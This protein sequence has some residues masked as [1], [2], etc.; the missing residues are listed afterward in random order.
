M[1]VVRENLAEKVTLRKDLKERRRVLFTSVER[2][3]QAEQRA[4]TK[5]LRI[6]CTWL[7]VIRTLILH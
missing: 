6:Q 2:V 7:A 3:F 5:A 1:E 4:G